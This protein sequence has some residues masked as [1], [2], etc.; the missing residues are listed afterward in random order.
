MC[1]TRDLNH[2]FALI[3]IIY[4]RLQGSTLGLY[5]RKLQ[6][7]TSPITN[8]LDPDY[9]RRRP[10]GSQSPPTPCTRPLQPSPAP[11]LAPTIN[12]H[13]TGGIAGAE[14]GVIFAVVA[15]RG[16]RWVTL[17]RRRRQ[18]H[19]VAAPLL[20]VLELPGEEGAP[21]LVRVSGD[22]EDQGHNIAAPSVAREAHA[23]VS[24]R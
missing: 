13:G 14:V 23:E 5:P 11:A 4:L 6:R 19:A 2:H 21:Y 8:P 12:G 20:Q 24:C 17:L 15:V 18:R 7:I 3:S 9:P 22:A 1:H 16:R 10:L